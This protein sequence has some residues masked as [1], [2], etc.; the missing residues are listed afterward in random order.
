M[1][2]ATLAPGPEKPLSRLTPMIGVSD[3]PVAMIYDA[4]RDAVSI[5]IAKPRP[6]LPGWPPCPTPSDAI[7]ELMPM[8][9][10]LP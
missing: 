7:A 3:V 4:M 8:T 6:I 2:P 1:T 9:A 10:P 5:G